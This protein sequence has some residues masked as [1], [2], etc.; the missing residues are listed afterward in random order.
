MSKVI[1]IDVS[2]ATFDIAFC[3]NNRWV[4]PNQTNDRK[5]FQALA[6]H[7]AAEDHC[8]ME[9]SVRALLF[10]TGNLSAQPGS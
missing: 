10:A 2:K 9:A 4:Y 1:G 5:G 7:V 8:I 3:E 6:K